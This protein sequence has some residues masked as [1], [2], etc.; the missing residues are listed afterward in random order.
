[1]GENSMLED[2]LYYKCVNDGSQENLQDMSSVC[3]NTEMPESIRVIY[4]VGEFVKPNLENSKLFVFEDLE[5]ARKFLNR[6]YLWGTKIYSCRVKNPTIPEWEN[7][8]KISEIIEFWK[9]V[10]RLSKLKCN[11]TGFE[12]FFG[13]AMVSS[14]TIICDEVQLIEKVYELK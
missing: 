3:Q 12:Q 4:K 9:N 13:A 10:D 14:G 11:E 8:V 1:M 7:Q 2:K 6:G 5:D